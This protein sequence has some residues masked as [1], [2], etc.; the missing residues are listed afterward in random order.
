MWV[1]RCDANFGR[2]LVVPVSVRSSCSVLRE[3]A[4]RGSLVVSTVPGFEVFA[5]EQD[6]PQRYNGV[7]QTGWDSALVKNC[8]NL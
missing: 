7:P 6:F 8:A 4:L 1:R 3:L 2:K 5:R